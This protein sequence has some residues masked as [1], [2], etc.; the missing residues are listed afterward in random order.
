[1]GTDIHVYAEVRRAGRWELA[2]AQE[3]NH[4]RLDEFSEEGP[5]WKPKELYSV[6]NRPLFAILANVCNPMWAVT[7]FEYIS[8]PRG[9]PQD[10]SEQL[11]GWH[12]S[13]DGYAVAESWLSLEELDAF[14]WHGKQIVRRGMVDPAA[15][16]LFPPGRRGFPLAEWPKGLPIAVSNQSRN[17]A[18]VRWIETYAEAAGDEFM[19]EAL[20]KLHSYGRPQDV[21]IVFWF[22][23]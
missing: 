1:M 14:D 20:E 13:W 16:H 9:L 15:A 6:R 8:A 22:D 3:E 18:E 17:G 19:I 21:R 5:E 10:L 11:L 2:E 4:Q 7:P 12:A 23:Q